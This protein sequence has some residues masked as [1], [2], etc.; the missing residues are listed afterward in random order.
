MSLQLIFNG[1]LRV[2]YQR[3]ERE[4]CDFLFQCVT[5]STRLT[6]SV[7]LVLVVT[8]SSLTHCIVVDVRI[9]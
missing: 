4:K 7:A 2:Y 6:L 3:E 1:Q 9:D 8:I 5:Y